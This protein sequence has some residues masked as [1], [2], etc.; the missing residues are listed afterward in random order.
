MLKYQLVLLPLVITFSFLA[1][2]SLGQEITAEL[3]NKD[4]TL[5]VSSVSSYNL[6]IKNNQNNP[7]N[8]LL[9]IKG[10]YPKFIF[11]DNTVL[12]LANSTTTETVTFN[13]TEDIGRFNFVLFGEVIGNSTT[14]FSIPVS[15]WVQH[16]DKYILKDFTNS[17][18]ENKVTARL[19]LEPHDKLAT[20]I[21]FDILD[22]NE[23]VVKSSTLS[24]PLEKEETV[25]QTIDISDLPTG[26]YKLSASIKGTQL[27]K[28]A[29]FDIGLSRNI[30]KEKTVTPG[31]LF[32][33]VKITLYNY[34]NLVEND[35][36]LYEEIGKHKLVT[37]ITNATDI[38]KSGD[39]L[40]YEFTIARIRPGEV[41]TIIYRIEAWQE[42]VTTLVIIVIIIVVVTT[43]LM[44]YRKPKIKKK[45][46]KRE[47]GQYS[48]ILEVKNSKLGELKDVTVKDFVQP[49]VRVNKHE[50]SGL[51]P[52]IRESQLGTE[53]VWKIGALKRNESRVIHY[54][55]NSLIQPESLKLSYATLSYV[56]SR[57]RRGQ[58]KSNELVLQ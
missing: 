32:N 51:A 28:T 1:S 19:T 22:I 6:T 27:T 34:G 2:A 57:N 20:E 17:V 10:E 33:E 7:L 18:E 31:L 5:N 30:K 3:S 41:A 56:T 16:P 21:V 50:T 23:K 58:I 46:V 47:K 44:M 12:A 35:Y 25:D 9:S 24:K 26:K 55:L 39:N 11:F 42:L 36:K 43:P 52:H 45:Y 14:N 8:F 49:L 29:S 15:L 4:I 53:L 37:L 13:P 54:T 48:V 40:R 38:L